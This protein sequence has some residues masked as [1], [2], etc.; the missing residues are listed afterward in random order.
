M[1]VEG[2]NVIGMGLVK[3][4]PNQLN[5]FTQRTTEFRPTNYN[6]QENQVR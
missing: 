2:F 3:W 6:H 1:S 4:L 5:K